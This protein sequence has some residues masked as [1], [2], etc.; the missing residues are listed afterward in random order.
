LKIFALGD[1]HLSFGRPK[2]MEVFGELWRDH[3]AKIAAAWDALVEPDDVVLVVGD[4]SWGHS[5]KEALPDL[6]FLA[7]RPGRLKL[8]LRGNHDSWW[9]SASKVRAA[10]PPGLAIVN[11]DAIRLEPGVV[12]CGAR[13]WNLP[14]M[15]WSDPDKDPAIFHRELERLDLSLTAASKLRQPGDVLIALLHFPPIGP[16]GGSSAVMQRLAAA[17]VGL[18][19]YGHLHGDDHAWAPDGRFD[20]VELRFVAVDHTLFAPRLIWEPGR[21]LI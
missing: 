12:L 13:G 10:L 17:H 5:L 20:G 9:T 11:N 2:P 21:G 15:P 19:A 4:I 3:P 8:L 16:G 18:A 14:D 7:D 1:P 6:Q